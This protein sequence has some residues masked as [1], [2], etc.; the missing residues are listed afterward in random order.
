MYIVFS[1]RHLC[2]WRK[3]LGYLSSDRKL[4]GAENL[5]SSVINLSEEVIL[6]VLGG[7]SVLSQPKRKDE[8]MSSEKD[9]KKTKVI[10]TEP[11]VGSIG[12]EGGR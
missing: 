10:N 11:F 1:P 12:G 9:G 3:R 7:I 2:P 5:P 4:L 6:F 8:E